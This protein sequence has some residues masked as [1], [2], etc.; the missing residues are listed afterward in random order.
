[1]SF[2]DGSRLLDDPGLN[3]V[4]LTRNSDTLTVIRRILA[5]RDVGAF[6]ALL[7]EFAELVEDC[8]PLG[9]L[10]FDAEPFDRVVREYL[11]GASS[12]DAESLCDALHAAVIGPLVTS[13][14]LQ[15][16]RGELQLFVAQ[17]FVPREHRMAACAALLTTPSVPDSHGLRPQE[18][19]ALYVLFRMQ[20]VSWLLQRGEQQAQLVAL[21]SQLE[22]PASV[23]PAR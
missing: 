16:F 9:Y 21:A 17:P 5:S 12:T 15:Y 13:D 11:A 2:G 14:F 1:M 7:N 22:S 23:K 18:L 10:R 19:P 3:G 4:A 6:T 20:L 8:G